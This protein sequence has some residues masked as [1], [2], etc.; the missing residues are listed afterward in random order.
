MSSMKVTP[1][2][3]NTHQ[4]SIQKKWRCRYRFY[5]S[6]GRVKQCYIIPQNFIKDFSL[7]RAMMKSLMIQEMNMLEAGYNPIEGRYV[8]SFQNH[9]GTWTEAVDHVVESLVLAET[10]KRDMVSRLNQVKAAAGRLGFANM[11]VDHVSKGHIKAMLKEA[12]KS[13]YSYNKIRAYLMM[14]YKELNELDAVDTNYVR[15]ISK[16]KVTVKAREVLT[17]SQRQQVDQHL[18]Q[19]YPAFCRYLHIFYHSGARSTEL[20]SLRR[21]DVD[22]P[23][24]RFKTMI[25]KGKQNREVWRIIQDVALPY[26]QDLLSTPGD[27]V[28]SWGLKPGN[29]QLNFDTITKN[30]RKWVKIPL[31]ITAEF[32]SVKHLATTE[33][34][35]ELGEDSAV[36]AN[37]HTSAAMVRTIY[38]LKNK[39]R[40]NENIKGKKSKFA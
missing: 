19:K 14:V 32:Y 24:Q 35:D 21:E 7:R 8:D 4:I 34:V 40:M 39:T 15:D 36:L 30:W 6:Q 33:M 27:F 20:L 13:A 28:F 29:K 3:W 23:G 5:D 17:D 11:P 2:N 16:A 31:G 12:T 18:R 9:L 26:W 38:D 25:K 37:A 22:L 10:T 1:A